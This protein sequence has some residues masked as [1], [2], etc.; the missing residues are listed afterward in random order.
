MPV[1]LTFDVGTTS[2]KTALVS[3]DGRLLAISATEY[4]P[5]CPEPGLAEMEAELYWNAVVSGTRA[6]F[7]ES[8]A[9][10]GDLASIGLCSQ[11]QTFVPLNAD[12]QPLHNAI[13]WID[14]RA[15]DIVREWSSDW[16][17]RED[18]QRTCGYPCIPAELSVFKI[19][20]LA[21]HKPQA[22]RAW[23]FLC[24]PDY[25]GYRLTGETVTDP[26]IAQMTGLYDMRTSRWEPRML[27]AA[28]ISEDQ[29]PMV[30]KAGTVAAGIRAD[31]AAELGIPSE[32]PVVVGTNDQLAAALGAGN[33]RAG[34]VTETTGTA[35]SVLVSTPELVQDAP[36]IVGPHVVPGMHFA[37]SIGMTSAVVLKWFRDL[38]APQMPYQEF[39]RGVEN[40]PPGSDGL[41][42]LPHFTGSGTPHFNPDARGV[43]SGLGL[44]HTRAHIARA[45]ME[46][47]ACLLKECVEP[48]EDS[49]LSVELVRSLGG[50]ARSDL[51]LQMKADLLGAPVERPANAEASS[52][53]AAMLAAYGVGAFD[54]I[55][56][57]AEA[58]Y[59]PERVFEPNTGL[60]DT[61]GRVYARY[62]SLYSDLCG[63][64]K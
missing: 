48:L 24:L 49:G 42:V 59:R 13:V 23:K 9:K 3:D 5:Q 52:L 25:L 45:I 33:N 28:G 27:S 7:A 43:I 47:C 60:R 55:V 64:R 26:V 18:Y 57:A 22:H 16:L 29:L 2:L 53:G 37:L 58:W 40:V 19:A 56:E 54:S 6:V 17:S 46:S 39:L 44:G 15:R 61:Y 32:V 30:T 14:D 51:W 38:C 35:L 34:I 10:P 31:A 1:Y 11:G 21:R 20:W 62:T 12:G 4:T 63:K 36:V 41:T 50:A 8:G